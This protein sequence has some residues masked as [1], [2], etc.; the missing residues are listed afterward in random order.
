MISKG[1]CRAVQVSHMP[2]RHS[3]QGSFIKI[4]WF[5]VMCMFL[6]CFIFFSSATLQCK[7]RIQLRTHSMRSSMICLGACECPKFSVFGIR[8]SHQHTR[9]QTARGVA[10]GTGVW[11]WKLSS[12]ARLYSIVIIRPVSF[13]AAHHQILRYDRLCVCVRVHNAMLVRR[14]RNVAAAA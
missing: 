2:D 1:P 12:L 6:K 4:A 5:H 9:E 11:K 7:H 14:S 10:D 13:S 3:K 8:M